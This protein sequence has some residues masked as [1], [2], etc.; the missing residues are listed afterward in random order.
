MQGLNAGGGW[1]GRGDPVARNAHVVHPGTGHAPPASAVLCTRQ[2]LTAW[3]QSRLPTAIDCTPSRRSLVW[4]HVVAP[5]LACGPSD[6]WGGA[7]GFTPLQNPRTLPKP[8]L[9]LKIL[10]MLLRDLCVAPC[11]GPSLQRPPR[12]VAPWTAQR[13]HGVFVLSAYSSCAGTATL[14]GMREHGATPSRRSSLVVVDLVIRAPA[15]PGGVQGG[16]PPCKTR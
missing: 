2:L 5:C 14:R 4:G 13:T 15:T 8:R 16:L 10:Y 9:M 11:P 6:S 3:C 7:G 12:R 1:A